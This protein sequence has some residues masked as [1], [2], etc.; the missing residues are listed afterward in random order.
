MVKNLGCSSCIESSVDQRD[1]S[2]LGKAT[3]S[4]TAKLIQRNIWQ[5]RQIVG[6]LYGIIVVVD[7]D[8]DGAK[9]MVTSCVNQNICAT[10][11]GAMSSW[12]NLYRQI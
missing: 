6:G 3:P 12:Q 8:I 1:A 5:V 10:V 11:R 7:L 9:P 2:C 4:G